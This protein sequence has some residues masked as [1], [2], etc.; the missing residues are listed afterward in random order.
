MQISIFDT[1]FLGHQCINYMNDENLI[2]SEF[3]LADLFNKNI[4][5]CEILELTKIGQD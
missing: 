2:Y 1:E 3:C 5:G 4:K